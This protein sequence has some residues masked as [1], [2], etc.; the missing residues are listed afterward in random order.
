MAYMKDS[1]GRKLDGLTVSDRPLI[2]NGT[3]YPARPDA[4]AGTQTY[5]GPT[6]PTAALTGDHWLP[7]YA[8][9]RRVI[10]DTDFYTDVDDVVAMRVAAHYERIGT[11]DIL[12]CIVN[13]AGKPNAPAL[14]AYWRNG[15]G[16]AMQ[17]GQVP[18][19]W[20]DLTSTGVYQIGLNLLP[21]YGGTDAADYPSSTVAYRTLLAA[22]PDA[23]VEVL[24]IGYANALEALLAS[25]GDGISPLTGA[26]L[27]AAKVSHLWMMGGGYPTGT[28]N[29]FNRNSRTAT[30]I[31]NTLAAWPGSV[32]ITFLGY[33]VGASVLTGGI[34]AGAA[35][36]SDPLLRALVAYGAPQGRSSWDPMLIHL[37][38]LGPT[39]AGYTTVQG[40]NAVAGNGANTFTAGAGTHRYVVK[41]QA[42]QWYTDQIDALLVP[43][44][45]PVP[46]TGVQVLRACGAWV[47]ESWKDRRLGGMAPLITG[48]TDMSATLIASFRASDIA[49]ADGSVVT[50]VAAHG[51]GPA[52]SQATVAQQPTYAAS[53]GG[54]A[55]VAFNGSQAL[56]T[57]SNLTGAQAMTIHTLVRIAATP[58]ALSI[59]CGMDNAAN[60]QRQFGLGLAASGGLALGECFASN[61]A[62]SPQPAGNTQADN[63]GVVALNQW[64][65]LSLRITSGLIETY[66]NGVSGG[67]SP[68]QVAPVGSFPYATTVAA[69]PA[70]IGCRNVTS[71][72]AVRNGFTGHIAALDIYN[73]AQTDAQIAAAAAAM[74]A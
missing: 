45:E 34:L 41:V 5:Q 20:S 42:D 28:E 11:F 50:S 33:E 21:H 51:V 15:E 47:A 1:T 29:N 22:S 23:S 67:P 4:P 72:S 74:L 68:F 39:A 55:A 60:S 17:I 54:K 35:S 58:S 62:A 59:A 3:A 61:S 57:A 7:S 27:V 32:P 65:V 16:R 8:A 48:Q 43:G 38:A 37:A 70:S 10:I 52:W 56:V 12:G 30:A 13:T 24:S 36:S 64:A 49:A 25:S 14:D 73:G 66:I 19:A 46:P 9:A 71:V 69:V 2:H 18:S 40:T 44:R 6:A 26:Q 53:V 31:I 63:G